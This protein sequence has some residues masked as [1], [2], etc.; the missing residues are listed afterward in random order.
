VR[1]QKSWRAPAVVALAVAASMSLV[2]C[3]GSDDGNKPDA[4]VGKGQG[5]VKDPTSPQT[6]TFFSWVGN[7][8]TMKKFAADFHKKHPN[9]TIK[10]ENAPAEQAGQ[11]LS[12]RI[13]G[14]NAPD[15]A[16]INASDTADYAARGALVDLGNYMSRSDVVKP[17]DY[18]EGFKTFVTWE[19]KMWGLPYDGETTGLFYRTDRFQEAGIDGPPTTWDE[20]QA[21]AEKLTDT[22]N[23]KYGYEMFASES[24]YYWYPWLYQA[25][26]DVLTQDGKDIAFDSA[27][28]KKAADFYVNL[29]KYSPKD[30]LNSNSYD[31]RVAFAQGD[32]AMYMAGAWFA[33]TLADEYPD[34]DGKWAA[35]PLP[36][37]EAGCK[38]T[39]AGDSLV[40]FNKSK[41]TDAAW[42]WMEYL[43]QPENL[44]NWTYKT[45]GTLLPPTKSL[46][47]SPDLEKEKPVLKPFA[48]LMACGVASTV[49]NP[50]Y[51]RVETILNEELGKAIYGDQTAEE[52]LDNAAQQGRAILAR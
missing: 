8:P 7:E 34:I 25:G 35:A 23:D 4:N 44:A 30:Y 40:M 47:N 43:S 51:P 28:G 31:G 2:A 21:D 32:V 49:N 39:I 33:G 22:A 5:A 45:E 36:D 9:I 18:V 46:L 37:G 24:A 38:T 52:A 48:D 20:F 10:F 16:F 11:V 26:G 12:T 42:L 17:D 41:V 13:A 1:F 3:G 50:K 15:V 6:V 27:E 19:D 29:A 14:N